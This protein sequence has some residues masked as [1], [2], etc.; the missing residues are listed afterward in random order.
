[1]N[2][3]TDKYKKT[4]E[5]YKTLGK[6]YIKN[7]R[8]LTPVEFND[9]IKILPKGGS[10]LEVGCAGGRDAK[11]FFQKGFKVVGVDLVDSFLEEA[12]KL[13]PAAKFIKMDINRLKIKKDS[14]DAIWANAVLLNLKKKDIPK[15]LKKFYEI[16]KLDGK[17]HIRVKKGRGVGYK[18]DK[19]SSGQKRLFIYFSQKE[20]EKLIKGAGFKIIVSRIFSDESGRK[21]VKWISVWAKK[22]P[23]RDRSIEKPKTDRIPL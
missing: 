15:I 18:I 11:K 2:T 5:V 22:W 7:I 19:L 16:I 20:I 6:K 21:D 17:L 9:F 8:N 12:R 13:V 1:M 14:F 3:K 4:I 10:V 23:D